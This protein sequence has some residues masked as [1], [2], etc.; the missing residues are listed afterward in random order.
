MFVGDHDGGAVGVARGGRTRGAGDQRRAGSVVKHRGGLRVSGVALWSLDALPS[1]RVVDAATDALAAGL[2]S[3]S[4]RV[5]AGTLER[6]ATVEVPGLFPRVMAEIGLPFYHR[7]SPDG[8][9]V[10]AR[11]MARDLLRGAVSSRELA[12]RMHRV[13]GHDAHDLIEPLVS[14]DDAYDTI[15]FGGADEADL[16]QAM[17]E[18]AQRLLDASR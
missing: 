4:L 6:D 18:A 16:D 15:V 5:L 2:D 11:A 1:E 14:L 12:A 8:Q 10:A 9:L 13:F 3:Q 7:G 17:L